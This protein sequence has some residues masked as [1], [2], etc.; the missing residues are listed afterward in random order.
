[1]TIP[2][3]W[4]ALGFTSGRRTYRGN[5]LVGG[6]GN[7]D[8][9]RGAAADFTAPL[10]V[11]QARFPGHRILDEGDHRHVSGLSDVPYYGNKGV[12][13]LVNGVDTTAPKGTPMLKPRKPQINLA[14]MSQVAGGFDPLA[15]MSEQMP[16]MMPQMQPPMAPPQMAQSAPQAPL[17]PH[18]PK[19]NGAAI[20]GILGDALAA[21]GGQ[22]GVFAP[23]MADQRQ[24]EAEDN[25]FQQ[26][27]AAEIQARKEA[28]A[29]K[30]GEPVRITNSAGDEVEID[31]TTGRQRI[32]YAD[33]YGKPRFQS[34]TDPTTGAVNMTPIPGAPRPNQQHIQHLLQSGDKQNFDAKFGPGMADY[35]L[36]TYGGR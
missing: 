27:L 30:A 11:L 10:S 14:A 28:A 29:A 17:Q 5:R 16:Q 1:M 9:L 7:S 18:K 13:G 34:A 36:Q 12:A 6:V 2:A 25:R 23:M 19:L 20:M 15:P 35:Y 8:H 24:N 22:H 21:Y 26:R 33:P 31:P 4:G 3:G 32:L